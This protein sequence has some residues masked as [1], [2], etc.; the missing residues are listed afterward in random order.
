[1]PL[2]ERF[3]G[4]AHVLSGPGREVHS[5]GPRRIVHRRACLDVAWEVLVGNAAEPGEE[6]KAWRSVCLPELSCR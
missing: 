1:M 4:G 6:T 5:L 2:R 3:L